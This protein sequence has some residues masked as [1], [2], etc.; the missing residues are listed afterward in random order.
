MSDIQDFF[1][2]GVGGEVGVFPTLAIKTDIPSHSGYGSGRYQEG[3]S[4]NGDYIFLGSSSNGS[5]DYLDSSDV[6][7][8]GWP[9]APTDVLALGQ[10]SGLRMNSVGTAL[11]V[12]VVNGSTTPNTFQFATIDSGGNITLGS[13][14]AQQ[15]TT[16]FTSTPIYHASGNS[17]PCNLYRPSDTGSYF[18]RRADTSTFVQ[19]LEFD[20]TT[21]AIIGDTVNIFDASVGPINNIVCAY[22]TPSDTLFGGLAISSTQDSMT[23]TIAKAGTKK[24]ST[25]NYL[26]IQTGFPC[27]TS[28]VIF[29]EWKGYISCGSG[30][31][32]LIL[33]NGKA[34][35]IDNF[36]GFIDAVAL[37]GGIV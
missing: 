1:G 8:T 26:P 11:E 22:R 36:N 17:T 25:L 10:W 16:D 7:Q 13:A 18:I 27:T 24:I 34:V 35:E 31:S 37:A 12:V 19:E 28:G 4:G 15:P 9:I 21:G 5:I 20:E 29:L 23:F 30:S 3:F 6:S 2:G 32:N 14:G 33:K